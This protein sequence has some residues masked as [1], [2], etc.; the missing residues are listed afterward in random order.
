MNYVKYL[1]VDVTNGKGTRCTLFVSGCSHQCEGCYNESTWKKTA[2][3]KFTK[4]MED[5]IINDL[6]DPLIKRTGLSLSG[7]DPLFYGNL[8]DIL[9]LVKRVKTECRQKDIWLWSGYTLKELRDNPIKHAKRLEILSYVDYFID[10]KFEKELTD[11]ELYW[12][13]SSNQIIH[14]FEGNKYGF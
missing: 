6:T 3:F 10:G 7:G 5:Q 1:P 8:D 4:E 11:P 2:G 9:R 12:R 14:K 13:G